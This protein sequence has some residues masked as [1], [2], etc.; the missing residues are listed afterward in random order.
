MTAP[1]PSARGTPAGRKLGDGYQTL[2]AIASGLTI[3]F[4]E[5]SINPPGLE[6]DNPN[7]TSSMFNAKWRTFSPR[8]LI[9]MTPFSMTAQWDPRVYT[10]VLAMVNVPT[11]I[12]AHFPDGSSLAFYGFLKSFKP[13]AL[14][15]GKVPEATVEIVPTNQDPV[16]CVEA[17]PVYTAGSGTA[18]SC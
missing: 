13:A 18:T 2:V 15:E 11:T 9:T 12:T 3:S 8:H 14:E 17:A 16:S 10:D 1:T 7:D 4:W 6:G 5:K